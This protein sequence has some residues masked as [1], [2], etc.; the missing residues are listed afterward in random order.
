MLLICIFGLF[1]LRKVEIPHELLI[2]PR[3]ISYV[4]KIIEINVNKLNNR[5]LTCFPGFM[6]LLENLVFLE[7]QSCLFGYKTGFLFQLE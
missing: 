3:F 1:W 4:I 7:F 6:Q 5:H 2:Y